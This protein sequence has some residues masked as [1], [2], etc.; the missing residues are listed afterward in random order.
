MRV[1]LLGPVSVDDDGALEPRDRLALAALAVR[2]GQVVHRDELADALWGDDPPSTADK[3]V[4]I[5]VSHLR[6]VLGADA[7]ETTSGGY[8]LALADD[9]VDVDRFERLAARGRDLAA[10]GDQDR[11]VSAYRRALEP[12]R[13]RPYEELDGWA[14]GR[15]EA[16]RL[17]ELRRAVEED[18]LEARLATGD[19]RGVAAD[20]GPLVAAEPLR[21]RRWAILSMAQY[22]C[23]RQADALRALSMARATLVE[24]LGIE[25]SAEL[26]ELEAGILRQD[27]ELLGPTSAP[28]PSTECPYKG[29]APYDV[30]DGDSF[31]GRSAEIDELLA[32]LRS[33]RLVVVA[34]PSGSGKSSLVRAGLVPALIGRGRP[35]T[36]FTP[37]GDADAAL[38]TALSHAQDGSVLVV[39]QFEELFTLASA[40]E[41]VAAFLSRVAAYAA[42]RGQVVITIRDDQLSGLTHDQAFSR[43]AEQ[44]L[45]LVGPLTGEHLREAI[46]GPAAQA[47]LRLE[48]GL[49]EL[50]ARDTEGEPGALPLLSHALAETWRRRDGNVLTVEGYQATGAISGAVAR[51][52]DRL[53][54][55][56]PLAQRAILRSVMLRLVGPSPEGGPIRFRIDGRTLRGDADHER[57]VSLL[58][59]AR[60]V[61]TEADS[62]ELAH[63]ALARA[64][65]RL[66]S[67]LDEDAAGQRTLRHLA[68]AA[69]GWD[70]LGRPTT[71]LYRGARLEAALEW[72][73]GTEPDLTGVEVE[74]LQA[75]VEHASSERSALEA[76]ARRDSTQNRRL[77][78]LLVVAAALLVVALLAG[79]LAFTSRD[80]AREQADAAR[81]AETTAQIEALVSRS[82]NLRPNSRT[83]AA[84]LA[85]EAH[86]RAPGTLAHSALLGTFTADP[87][88]VGNTY[89]PAEQMVVGAAIP[90]TDEAVVALDG[91]ELAV[92]TVGE[93]D[94]DR[95]FGP[96]NGEQSELALTIR[97]S[98]DGRR[99]AQLST[100]QFTNPDCG[101][102]DVVRETDGEGCALLNVY[103][104]ESG[105][106]LLGAIVPPLGPGDVS[107]N[108]DG[109]LVAVA[110][111]YDGDVAVYR[112][113]DESLVDVVRRPPRPE[114]F[115]LRV[116]TATVAFGG[117][118]DL[119]YAGSPAGPID[120]IDPATVRVVGQL[121][122]PLSYSHGQIAVTPD[123]LVVAAGDD[124]IIAIDST[125][126]GTR[127]TAPLPSTEAF[128]CPVM[129]VAPETGVYF[130]ANNYGR[131]VERD[132]ANGGPT[133]RELATPGTVGTLA[134]A[135][136]E[137]ELL[138]FGED[139]PVMSRW[140][141]DGTG[142]ITTLVA[143]G[144]AVDSY[145]PSGEE[146]LVSDR[147]SVLAW[148]AVD[149]Q[150]GGL[151]MAVWDIEG[152][153]V[154]D[155]LDGFEGGWV[156]PRWLAGGFADGTLGVYDLDTRAKEPDVEVEQAEDFWYVPEAERTFSWTVTDGPDDGVSGVIKTFDASADAEGDRHIG[157]DIPVD[158]YV[159]S[160]SATAEG[161]RV[162]ITVFDLSSDAPPMPGGWNITTVYDGQTGRPVGEPI[163][164]PWI[165]QVSADG[166]LL[167]AV[168]GTTTEYDL[169][170]QRAIGDFPGEGGQVSRIEFSHDGRLA[171]VTS[172][173]Q[174]LSIYDVVTRSRLGDPIPSDAPL[175]WQGTLRPDG[176]ALAVTVADG[177]E[178][179]DLDPGRLA[180]A[181]C[182]IVGRN[183]TRTEWATYMSD[184]GTYRR[185]CPDLP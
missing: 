168:T 166:T 11:A 162:V 122:A 139:V 23:G 137:R 164:G 96:Y 105:R 12:W 171:L 114:G 127:W 136:G 108:A 53:Y 89:F 157:P 43:L 57:I 80:E 16:A 49:I 119:L 72:R 94:V 46:E 165:T 39:D 121:D 79:A 19:H 26:V 110:G 5:C 4:Q 134:V 20:A 15:S 150:A 24:E 109:S 38:T 132:L 143:R 31:F 85:V 156:A 113:D 177:V 120:V 159:Q 163:E 78:T 77:R 158:G 170:T 52:A 50:L 36:V 84:L 75:S 123:G 66:Q 111:G 149:G 103:D 116:D 178:I 184:L 61:T 64:W 141:L 7:I 62:V 161:R 63:E 29:L 112:V 9:D 173:D 74:F 69:V 65:P 118:D 18:L 8:R 81:S 73:D 55:S 106:L 182:Q 179:W 71:E 14:P 92:V 44:G 86:R 95:R 54:E 126:R 25:P 147:D 142:P 154:L 83:V 6:R 90:G 169:D 176:E 160:V 32:R 67:W 17:E 97:V 47:G 167:G 185:T 129:T 91:K 172:N 13:G 51:S 2:R 115:Q 125:T 104:I 33:A 102:L 138:A 10:T 130:C 30:G 82:L 174:S 48:G 59:G 135:D 146:M 35:V 37:G 180:E 133:G 107:L 40:T 1:H 34:G 99:V 60:L 45:H 58:V 21:E 131:V 70:S 181:T 100:Q 87:T 88:F 140:R 68:A 101:N 144:Q 93:D 155:P 76:R 148:I 152:D 151:D 41:D 153:A 183:L 27:P 124:G 98:A 175:D 128:V 56:L 22:R 28:S 3:Q 117:P 145:G 42:D